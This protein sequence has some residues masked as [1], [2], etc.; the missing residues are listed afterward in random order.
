M[1]GKQREWHEHRTGSVLE[2][3]L[4]VKHWKVNV[5]DES[6]WGIVKEV[7]D[8]AVKFVSGFCLFVCF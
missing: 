4:L 2:C 5:A 1:L 3:G 6:M 8:R 7:K